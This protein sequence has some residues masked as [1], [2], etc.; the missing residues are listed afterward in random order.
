MSKTTQLIAS[1]ELCC[2]VPCSE[3]MWPRGSLVLLV[4]LIE[5]CL[6]HFEVLRPRPRPLEQNSPCCFEGA[7]HIL[8]VWNLSATLFRA[9][10]LRGVPFVVAGPA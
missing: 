4:G 1:Q 2:G 8:E 9:S 6:V 7:G 3:Q 5:I 10:G